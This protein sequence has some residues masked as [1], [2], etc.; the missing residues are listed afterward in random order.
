MALHV[1]CQ[2]REALL[3][4]KEK[5]VGMLKALVARVPRSMMAATS[6][7]FSELERQLKAKA[8]SIEEVDQQRK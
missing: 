6:A 8:S 3:R 7:K 5:L 2:V 4:K 1:P